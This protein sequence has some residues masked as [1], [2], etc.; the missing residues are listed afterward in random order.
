MFPW[1]IADYTSAK[2]DLS[3]P[4]TYRDLRRPVG[5]LT[6]ERL[7]TCRSRYRTFQDETIPSF[8]YGSHYSTCVGTVLHYLLRVEPFTSL[9]VSFQDGHFDVPDRLFFSVPAAWD[10]CTTSMSE[11]QCLLL[12]SGLLEGSD[13]C[14]LVSV[15]SR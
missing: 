2:L 9:H 14:G 13:T 12:G 4:A 5:A 6:R 8:M 7:M 3:N 11:V 1:I 15:R 10:L